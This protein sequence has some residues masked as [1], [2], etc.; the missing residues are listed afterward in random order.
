[1]SEYESESFYPSRADLEVVNFISGLN[2]IFDN[3]T[4]ILQKTEKSIPYYPKEIIQYLN[5]SGINDAWANL[6]YEFIREEYVKAWIIYVESIAGEPVYF[7]LE[8][9][10]DGTAQ[11]E[12]NE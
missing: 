2:R 8:D 4:K 1:M 12:L 7:T 9:F 10:L 3:H 11:R 5:F 6:E